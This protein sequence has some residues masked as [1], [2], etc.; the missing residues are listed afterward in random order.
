[1]TQSVREFEAKS[2]RSLKAIRYPVSNLDVFVGANGVGKTNL[3]RAL[4]LLRSAAANTLARDLSREGGLVSAMWAGPRGRSEAARI[5]LA[6][7]LS[8]E[9]E[10]RS[11][12]GLYRYEVEVGFPPA[13]AS[14]A[15]QAEP[16]IKMEAVSYVGGT[17]TTRLMDRH[18]P[19]VMARAENGRPTQI[20]IDLLDSETVLGRLEDPSR[21]PELDVL[22]RTLLQWRFYHGLRTD[23]ASPLRQPCAAVATPTLGSDGSDLAA[24]FATLVHIRQDATDLDRVV[25]S[26]FPG[27]KLIVP[28]PG[29][30]ASFGMSFPEFPQRVFDAQELSD[31]TLRF[32]ALA[33][34][35]L[36][37][38][39]P[40]FIALNEPEASL[41]PDLMEPLAQ[42]V[43]RAAERTQLWLVTHSNRLA[44]AIVAAGRGQVRTVRKQGGATQIEGL[45]AWGAFADEDD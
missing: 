23:A 28:P 24:V 21:Y 25:D 44:D 12:K 32:L 22:R 38:R 5:R 34:A 6:V 3:Y 2:F 19:S 36:A 33:G 40:P 4:E 17:R 10:N 20:D 8:A 45:K 7:G 27:A 15:F 9:P 41:H 13:E 35:L 18:G 16:Q 37:Y 39:L 11:S 31:G 29:R 14:A 42:L 26:A 30:V 43:V 1:M